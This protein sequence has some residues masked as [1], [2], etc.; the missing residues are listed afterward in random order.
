MHYRSDIEYTYDGTLAGFLCCIHRAFYLHENP[1]A[2]TAEHSHQESFFELLYVP[3]VPEQARRVWGSFPKKFGRGAERMI[4][5]AYLNREVGR[6]KDILSFLRLAYPMGREAFNAHSF[7]EVMR[8]NRL[9]Q[10]TENECHLLLGFLRFEE[11]NGALAAVIEP[12]HSPLPLMRPHFVD[13]FPEERFIIYDKTN[14]LALVYQ[15]HD[16]RILHIDSLTLPE[17]EKKEAAMQLL[18]AQYY[19]TVAIRER[20]NPRCRMTHMPKRFWPHM[21]EIQKAHHLT[22][23][24][25]PHDA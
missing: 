7:P 24:I 16:W 3:T 25:T 9:A 8:F 21:T 17:M 4:L 6:E 2:I 18:W 22:H 20:E 10:A 12:K 15:P 14:H 1:L 13:R 11:Y 23:G 19:K 5:A